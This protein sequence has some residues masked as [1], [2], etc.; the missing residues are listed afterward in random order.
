MAHLWTEAGGTAGGRNGCVAVPS[1]LIQDL[2]ALILQF[3][4]MRSHSIL[5]SL[6][7]SNSAAST[8]VY[9]VLAES[10]SEHLKF[11]NG[12]SCLETLTLKGMKV[13]SISCRSA[14]YYKPQTDCWKF[15]PGEQLMKREVFCLTSTV[16]TF[17]SKMISGFGYIIWIITSDPSPSCLHCD[18]ISTFADKLNRGVRKTWSIPG[19]GKQSHGRVS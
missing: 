1:S 2:K 17:V 12:T 7:F 15:S 13:M 19:Y 14:L 11:S 10:T 3:F 16:F 18:K 5:S 6:L 4:Y 8:L 9:S